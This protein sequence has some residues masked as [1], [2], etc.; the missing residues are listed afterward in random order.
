METYCLI[1][2]GAKT[3]EGYAKVRLGNRVY[4]VHRI[5][6]M[7]SKGEIP[8]GFILDHLCRRRDCINPGHLEPVTNRVN[9]LRGE[10]LAAKNARKTHCIRGHTFSGAN[11]YFV[12][13]KNG[14]LKRQCRTC[15]KLYVDLHR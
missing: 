12:R 15:Q 9:I 6:W 8:N 10:S 13:A 7:Q 1:W 11:L 2:Q 14:R 5:A 4:A 3:L